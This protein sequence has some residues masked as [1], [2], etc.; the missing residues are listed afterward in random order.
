VLFIL[1]T[2]AFCDELLKHAWKHAAI[3]KQG[4]TGEQNW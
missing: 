2:L 3:W 4:L 1:L